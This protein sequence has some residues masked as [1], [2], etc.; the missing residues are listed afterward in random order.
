[1]CVYIYMCSKAFPAYC[2]PANSPLNET[3]LALH[4]V[5]HTDR[6]PRSGVQIQLRYLPNIYKVWTLSESE[7]LKSGQFF[8]S[9]QELNI[10]NQYVDTCHSRSRFL[11]RLRSDL[12][13][14]LLYLKNELSSF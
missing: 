2:P 8:A 10:I 12:T 13:L 3:L 11:R 14:S 1:M 5:S 4:F 7:S 9:V 6:L